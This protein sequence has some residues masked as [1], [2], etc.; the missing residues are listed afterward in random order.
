M[1]WFADTLAASADHRVVYHE[2][3]DEAGN[4]QGSAR[5]IVV[6]VNGAPL[7]GDTR[8]YAEA[9]VHFAAGMTLVA[10]ATP[11]FFMGEEVGASLPYRFA[12]FLAAR[13]DYAALRTGAGANLFRFYADVIRLR[14]AHPA[15]RS[16]DCDIL[17]ANDDNRVIALRRWATGEE[18]I[19]VGS[20]NNWA[21]RGGYRIQD[22]RIGDG[23]WREV[24]NSDAAQYG[25]G[26]LLNS[27]QITSGGGA[28][29]VD[30]PANSVLVLQ[31]R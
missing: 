30:I 5:T 24:F 21:F 20:L 2:S 31:R 7:I 18:M 26:G 28:I 13:E 29:S 25:G 12:D 16:H 10:P 8:R 11:M 4:A 1:R 19:V 17:H 9:R 22:S 6:A 23:E 27:G 15:L 14:L 3:H